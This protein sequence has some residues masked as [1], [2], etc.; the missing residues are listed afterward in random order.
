MIVT[1]ANGCT[2]M[3]IIDVLP[4]DT[5]E[6]IIDGPSTIF[7]GDTGDF[8]YV[9][10]GTTAEVSDVIW[11][12]DTD[13]DGEFEILELDGDINLTIE[14]FIEEYGRQ[15]ELRVEVYFSA[16]CFIDADYRVDI[17][18]IEKWYIPNVISPATGGDNRGDNRW[19]MYTKGGVT[20]QKYSIYDRWGELV[21]FRD[22]D[23]MVDAIQLT[24]PDESA[25]EWTL[26]W[27]GEWGTTGTNEGQA[28]QGVYVYVIEM[29][30]DEGGPDERIEI[31]AGDITVFR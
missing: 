3:E 25:V 14:A 11:Y 28:E 2:V 7:N 19:R 10:T 24:G 30:I 23:P 12:I 15:F 16:D 6:V 5:P 31:E 9:L 13:Q 18:D 21:F 1:D 27:F 8:N 22:L 4:A 29:V 17:I 26:D 20:V